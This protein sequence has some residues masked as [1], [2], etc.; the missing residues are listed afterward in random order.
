MSRIINLLHEMRVL[1]FR[2][3]AAFVAAIFALFMGGVALAANEHSN[4]AK[5]AAALVPEHVREKGV[6]NVG[7]EID[8]PPYEFYAEDGKTEIGLDIDMLNAISEKLNL[9]FRLLNSVFSTYIPGLQSGRFD[10]TTAI[11]D[12]PERQQV[13]GFVN[14]VLAGAS[15]TLPKDNKHNIHE[16][17]DLCGHRVGYLKGSIEQDH[18]ETQ[19][20]KCVS[21]GKKELIITVFPDTNV[22]LLAL[23]TG[24][25]DAVL[26][27]F[28]PGVYANQQQGSIFHV[29]PPYTTYNFGFGFPKGQP[30]LMQAFA[31]ALEELRKD[32]TYQKI[33]HKWEMEDGAIDRFSIT[34]G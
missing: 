1:D 15:I 24:R 31:A 26:Q 29:L 9:K 3:T 25:I 18:A 14:Y 19:S 13:I 23:K 10:L 11:A 7:S 16:L 6:L 32:G 34:G 4:A 8:Y 33:L 20:K 5:D 21:E 12:T 22:L 27:D 28:G 17:S 2:R 30:E